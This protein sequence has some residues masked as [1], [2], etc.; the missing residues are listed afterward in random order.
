MT[1]RLQISLLALVAA[2]LIGGLW[3]YLAGTAAPPSGTVLGALEPSGGTVAAAPSAADQASL[4]APQALGP[5]GEEEEREAVAAGEAEPRAARGPGSVPSNAVWLAGRVLFRDGTPPDEELEIEARGNKFGTGPNADRRYRAKVADDG[6]FRVAFSK[7]TRK[8]WIELEGRYQYLEA[9]ERVNVRDLPADF[10]LEPKLGGI[11][12]GRVLPPLGAAFQQ[13]ALAG[14][15]VSAFTWGGSNV[16]KTKEVDAEGRFELVGLPPGDEYQVSVDSERYADLGRD[17]VS[18]KPGEITELELALEPGLRLRGRVVDREGAGVAQA[19]LQIRTT[20]REGDSESTSWEMR[21]SAE[22]GSFDVGGL[23]GDTAA[24]TVSHQGFLQHELNLTGLSAGTTREGIVIVLERGSS[25]AGIVQWPDGKPAAEAWVRVDQTGNAGWFGF[26]PAFSTKVGADGKFEISGL[27]EADCTVLASCRPLEPAEEEGGRRRKKGAAWRRKIEHVR[28]GARGLVIEL[29]QGDSIYGVVV[30]DTGAPI[31]IFRVSSTPVEE[32]SPFGRQSG[33]S[34]VFRS[35]DGDFELGG[36][37]PGL[38]DVVARA[39]HHGISEP[40]RVAAPYDGPELRFV[41]PR[42]ARLEGVVR[43]PGGQPVAGAGVRVSHEGAGAEGGGII[44]GTGQGYGGESTK[45]DDQ[46]AFEFEHLPPGRLEL[47]ADAAGYAASEPLE[48]V[49]PPAAE[50][51][52]T[53]L[54]LRRAGRITGVVHAAAGRVAE[55]DIEVS[56]PGAN[57]TVKSDSSGRFELDGLSPGTYTVTLQG[58]KDPDRAGSEG[59]WMLRRAQ[60][61]EERVELAEG[62]TAHVVL[63]APPPDPILVRGRV[64]E[65]ERPVGGVVVTCDGPGRD[66]NYGARTDAGGGFE[67]TVNGPGRYSFSVGGEWGSQTRFDQEIPDRELVEIV[68]T[69][70]T[71][72]LAGTITGPGGEALAAVEVTLV[73]DQR[74]DEQGG[75]VDQRQG[76]TDSSGAFRFEN[77]APGEYTLQAGGGRPWQWRQESE[78][79]GRALRGGLKVERGAELEGIDLQLEPGGTVS[80]TVLGPD[81]RGVQGASITITTLGGKQTSPWSYVQ[82]GPAGHFTHGGVAPG[83]WLASARKASMESKPVEVRVFADDT[84]TVELHL[85]QK[86]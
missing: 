27:K 71:A 43:D 65:A 28:P 20:S 39:K 4:S 62:R 54:V 1:G 67:L 74:A 41:L 73:C 45:S 5:V 48:V 52:G 66:R 49:A 70:P 50:L 76:T 77:L 14:V 7:G 38:H 46:G 34:E 25:V 63:G 58:D 30:D 37:Q 10:V 82:S 55:R 31:D 2:A 53:V 13:G 26:G 85:A 83:T 8:G 9:T 56:G 29:A 78:V 42:A 75:R 57:E 44:W 6:A 36:I 61:R 33:A 86:E 22:D 17:A 40:Q 60:R 12:R 81:G 79:Y 19:Q 16:R 24:I 80:G 51:S 15:R 47:S 32:T 21:Q 68:L 59:E 18:V 64:S 35:A 23:K 72:S 69:L 84:V 3:A 11:I